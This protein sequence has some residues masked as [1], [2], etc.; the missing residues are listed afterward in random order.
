MQ[1]DW[2]KA[3]RNGQIAT[4]PITVLELLYSARSSGDFRE[5]EEELSVLR[6]VPISASVWTA[7]RT[8]FRELAEHS[9]G[10]H[11]VALPDLLVA[12]AAQDAALGVL[13]YDHHF[14]RLAE[15]LNFE[16]RWVAPAGTLED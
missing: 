3:L 16:S 7:A 4:C 6:L 2:E 5:L 8:A 13:H 15:V 1:E 10:Y 9:D 14:D 11:R 12:A